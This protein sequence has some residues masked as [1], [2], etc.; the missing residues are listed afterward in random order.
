MSSITYLR[1]YAYYYLYAIALTILLAYGLDHSVRQVS[2]VT[3]TDLRPTIVIDAGHGGMDS[4]TTSC[5]G[6][7]E[8]TLNLQIARRVDLVFRLLG[9]KT[10]MTR[11]TP[12]AL[13]TEGSTIHAKKVSDL[14]NRVTM[15]NE[16]SNCILISIHQNYYPESR[17]YG[18]QVFYTETGHSLADSVQNSLNLLTPD[19]HRQCKPSS[20][21]YLMEHINHPGILVECGFLSNPQEETKIRNENYQKKLACAIAGAAAAHIEATLI[22]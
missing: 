3:Q 5:T 9:Y 11:T 18:P 22:S 2:T 16:H 1:R 12:D 7:P 10:Q 14:K 6:M 8:S 21:I 17:Y 20:G 13:S 15:V 4:G 19:I